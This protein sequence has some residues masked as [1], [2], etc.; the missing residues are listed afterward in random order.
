VV[1]RLS[2]ETPNFR[3]SS[4]G[5]VEA[6]DINYSIGDVLESCQLAYDHPIEVSYNFT[7]VLNMLRACPLSTSAYIA[8]N[9]EGFLRVQFLHPVSEQR[10]MYSEYTFSPLETF[11]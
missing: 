9:Q 5:T 3:I 4:L 11:D 10:Y 7:H 2:P 8:I 6:L 1:L